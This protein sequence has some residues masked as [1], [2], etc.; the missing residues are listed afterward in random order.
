MQTNMPPSVTGTSF[1][2]AVHQD[3]IRAA[4]ASTGIS[5]AVSAN[6]ATAFRGVAQT[7]LPSF[8]EQ[9][10][11]PTAYLQLCNSTEKSLQEVS[12][13]FEALTMELAALDRYMAMH[14]FDLNSQIKQVLVEQRMNLVKD[15]DITRKYKEHLEAN[16]TQQQA[17]VGLSPTFAMP[18]WQPHVNQGVL[19]FG[20]HLSG[21]PPCPSTF[22]SFSDGQPHITF[23]NPVITN[24][25]ASEIS[26]CG[27]LLGVAQFPP[28]PLSA[29]LDHANPLWGYGN[30]QS[31]VDPALIAH[32]NTSQAYTTQQSVST[33]HPQVPVRAETDSLRTQGRTCQNTEE[34]QS[35]NIGLAW[36][37][38]PEK[39]TLEM[40]KK[41]SNILRVP[42]CKYCEPH[43]EQQ[44]NQTDVPPKSNERTTNRRCLKKLLSKHQRKRN[45]GVSTDDCFNKVEVSAIEQAL[46]D[47]DISSSNSWA[48]LCQM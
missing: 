16:W 8:P 36:V 32:A 22:Q 13:E 29:T 34:V 15:L 25:T 30:F 35:Q 39:N 31:F 43:F 17:G 26:P 46:S 11:L 9:A 45:A 27:E 6:P 33:L 4:R 24:V 38:K 28:F 1:P 40:A 2:F 41:S 3:K 23:T 48:T 44:S 14:T 47:S 7:M 10:L 42:G 12:S 5:E 18:N 21:I 20:S 37:G 19:T